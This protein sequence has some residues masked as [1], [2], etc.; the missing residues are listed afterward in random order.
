M[1]LIKLTLASA[2]LLLGGCATFDGA[3][4][5]P[6]YRSTLDSEVMAY[7]EQQAR[8][9][10]TSVHWINPPRKAKAP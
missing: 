8:R 5:G 6:G 3:T 10:G 9:N 2:A 1:K 4:T 7:V